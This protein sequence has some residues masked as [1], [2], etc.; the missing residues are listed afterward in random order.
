MLIDIWGIWFC[1]RNSGH[2][3]LS[4]QSKQEMKGLTAR[5]FVLWTT[6]FR[7][8]I[9]EFPAK[10]IPAIKILFNHDTFETK[11]R[12]GWGAVLIIRSQRVPLTKTRLEW[13]LSQRYAIQKC[14][15]VGGITHATGFP[16]LSCLRMISIYF[17]IHSCSTTLY[18]DLRFLSILNTDPLKETWTNP[19]FN[20]T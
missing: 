4:C 8:V 6:V 18:F 9:I 10:L 19:L 2:L 1:S 7:L 5:T 12:A 13:G 15:S 16:S 20:C 3:E 17:W 11:F 14:Y